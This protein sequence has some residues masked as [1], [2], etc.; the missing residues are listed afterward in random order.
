MS[1][2][3]ISVTVQPACAER[4]VFSSASRLMP[5]TFDWS[6][7]FM[8]LILQS[9]MAVSDIDYSIGTVEYRRPPA[10]S[11]GFSF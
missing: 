10:Q 7:R 4:A 2:E 11:I 5:W 6:V 3:E 1:R 9:S 8:M